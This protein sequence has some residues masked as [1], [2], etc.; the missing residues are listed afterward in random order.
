M[1][2]LRQAAKIVWSSHHDP[3]R[4]VR[5]RRRAS[6]GLRAIRRYHRWRRG[7]CGCTID[8]DFDGDA[9]NPAP[10]DSQ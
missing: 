4:H 3:R 1:M 2:R 5:V 7:E 6:T 10:T 9:P 8:F